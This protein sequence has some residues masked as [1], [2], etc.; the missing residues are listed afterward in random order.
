MPAVGLG[1]LAGCLLAPGPIALGG[2]AAAVAWL[3]QSGTP[4]LASGGSGGRVQR[5]RSIM[6]TSTMITIRTMV[7]IPINM[8]FL[9]GAHR[10]RRTVLRVLNWPS[11]GALA[12]RRG[13]VGGLSRATPG[14]TRSGEPVSYFLKTSLIFAGLLEV[15]LGLIGVALGLEGLIAGGLADDLLEIAL[16][17]LEGVADLVFCAHRAGWPVRM[18]SSGSSG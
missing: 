14:G 18:S 12:D 10:P 4:T 8:E 6:M 9:S 3:A 7:P 2:A 16:G 5:R 11:V 15:A 13:C 1:C 17:R